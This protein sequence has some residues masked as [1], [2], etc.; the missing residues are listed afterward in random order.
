MTST[1][2]RNASDEYQT[3]AQEAISEG[4][5]AQASEKLWG[6]AAQAVKA[7][8]EA[9]GWDH[10]GHAQLFQAVRRLAQETDDEEM[11]ILFRTAG[12][13]HTNF[14][15][16]WLSFQ[17]VEESAEDVAKLLQKL[18]GVTGGAA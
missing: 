6:A 17:D 9:R 14:Y 2:Y 12:L 7:I 1:Q 13:L 11:I 8:A 10:A 16:R 5:Y 18:K 15:E 3:D 4:K